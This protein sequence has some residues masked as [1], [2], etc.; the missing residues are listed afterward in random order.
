[1]PHSTAP[2]VSTLNYT[3]LG[4]TL[5]LLTLATMLL[6]FAIA[7]YTQFFLLEIVAV[8]FFGSVCGMAL[9]VL[10][11]QRIE[12]HVD[13]VDQFS[14]FASRLSLPSATIHQRVRER[15]TRFYYVNAENP[16]ESITI[17]EWYLPAQQLNALRQY[18]QRLWQGHQPLG[19]R[20]AAG[21]EF[22]NATSAFQVMTLLVAAYT[23]IFILIASYLSFSYQLFAGYADPLWNA[24]CHLT[25]AL[26]VMLSYPLL[27][28]LAMPPRASSY[29]TTLARAHR[30]N[31]YSALL[32]NLIT[33][34]GLPLFL[35]FGNR[36]DVYGLLLIGAIF[37]RDFYPRLSFWEKLLDRATPNTPQSNATPRRSL[38][39]SLALLGSMTLANQSGVVDGFYLHDN[40]CQDSSG[41]P[42]AC[43]DSG[44]SSYGN[45]SGRSGRSIRRGGFGSSGGI[46]WSFGG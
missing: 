40:E 43:D 39:I 16:R 42:T 2:P 37:Y 46:H 9:D 33:W 6:L 7:L 28:Q 13:R 1:M 26:L 35:M 29:T 27:R 4:K 23:I 15:S 31:T 17:H 32:I 24:P 36:L 34:L 8:Y 45:S 11:T 25:V 5:A 14:H 21:L 12:L 44:G 19:Q 38:Q 10:L 22:S 30:H 20:T 18:R 3:F 41:K